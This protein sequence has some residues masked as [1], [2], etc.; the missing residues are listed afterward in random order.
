[1]GATVARE[2]NYDWCDYHPGPANTMEHQ[3]LALVL[4]NSSMSAS[5]VS[6]WAAEVL[7]QGPRRQQEG[8]RWAAARV[9]D[10]DTSQRS[11]G[12]LLQPMV[13]ARGG[14]RDA[15]E[16]IRDAMHSIDGA[17]SKF[18]CSHIQRYFFEK[19]PRVKNPKSKR[20]GQAGVLR[21]FDPTTLVGVAELISER[22]AELKRFLKEPEPQARAGSRGPQ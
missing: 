1:M 5:D 10:W 6:T 16:Q 15:F 7:A 21:W 3:L 11:P 18:T 14:A 9:S 22:G 4:L 19:Q 2:A 17:Y 8:G 13:A 12:R 20:P